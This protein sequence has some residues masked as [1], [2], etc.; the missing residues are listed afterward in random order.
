VLREPTVQPAEQRAASI[1]RCRTTAPAIAQTTEVAINSQGE[2]QMQFRPGQHD[3]IDRKRV[4][5][6]KARRDAS[7]PRTSA[8]PMPLGVSRNPNTAAATISDAGMPASKNR[9]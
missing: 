4:A 3:D 7:P 5:T 2:T 9:E 8:L 1:V 6:G